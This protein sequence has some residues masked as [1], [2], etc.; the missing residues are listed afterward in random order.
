[1][2]GQNRRGPDGQGPMTGRKMGRC[3]PENTGKADDETLLGRN[4]TN[5]GKGNSFSRGLARGRNWSS[6]KGLG[7]G[8]GARNRGNA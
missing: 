7:R 6:G 2:P 3:N 4:E 1:M 8:M 5:P